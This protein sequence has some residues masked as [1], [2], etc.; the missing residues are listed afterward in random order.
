MP[1]SRAGTFVKQPTGYVSFVPAPLPP[2]PELKV[3]S[4][5]Q[6]ILSRADRFLGRLDGITRL[7]PNPDLFVD[8]YVK[9]E[10][11][12]SSQIEG[13]Q[14]SFAEII[15]HDEG[16]LTE[17]QRD[18]S[19]YVAALNYGIARVK[20]LP[21]SLRLL[22]EI[23]A[24]LLASGRGSNRSPGEFRRSQNWIGAPGCTLETAAFVPPCVPDMEAALG[25]L[26]R[27]FYDETPMAPLLKIGLIHAQFESI[28]PFLDGNG[29]VGRLLIT[30]WLV[31]QQ[32]LTKPLLYLSLYFKRHRA[33]YYELLMRV[34]KEGD[35]EAWTR[36]F[37]TGV[38]EV[39]KDACDSAERIIALQKRIEAQVSGQIAHQALVFLFT[40][41]ILTASRLAT[42]LGVSA[43]TS[44]ALVKR[45]MALGILEPCPG[46]TKQRNI[47]YRFAEYLDILEADKL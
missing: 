7:L 29:R 17:D 46:Q 45:L 33:T 4:E 1:P 20:E 43:P 22:R 23:H 10:S 40:S 41:P 3:D 44:R 9:K 14:A 26:E 38:A 6:Q 15:T 28:H 16:E 24:K 18:V 36:F 42:A 39:S 31:H 27:F 11:L 47:K 35:W 25:A 37:L 8:M 32:I 5:L 19:N 21:L 12:L 2:Q 13:T 34:R 30:F